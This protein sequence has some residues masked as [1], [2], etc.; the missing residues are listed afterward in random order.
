MTP[1]ASFLDFGELAKSLLLPTLRRMMHASIMDR[2]IAFVISGGNSG[3]LLAG[4]L[5]SML[6]VSRRWTD[7]W[8][9][10]WWQ[11]RSLAEGKQLGISA[12]KARHT[13]RQFESSFRNTANPFKWN[14]IG[15][16]SVTRADLM[17]HASTRWVPSLARCWE[18]GEENDAFSHMRKEDRSQWISSRLS[19]KV[20]EAQPCPKL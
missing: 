1:L 15:S 14:P 19:K 18:M 8:A 13:R 4:N 12:P 3:G 2:I 5:L 7:L 17:V 11:K 6:P 9:V 20:M 16:N 10:Y